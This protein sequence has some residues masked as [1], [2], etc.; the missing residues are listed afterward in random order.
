MNE[1]NTTGYV[2]DVLIPAHMNESNTTGY[3]SDVLISAHMLNNTWM[4]TE[5]FLYWWYC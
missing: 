1:S 3:V 4:A 2:S 5:D